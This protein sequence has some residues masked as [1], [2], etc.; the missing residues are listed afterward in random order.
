MHIKFTKY[1]GA[2][3][4]FIILN[5]FKKD[6]S[7]LKKSQIRNLCNRHFGIGAD[8]LILINKSNKADFEMVYHNADGKVGSMCGNGARC[9]VLFCI[10]AGL[11]KNKAMFLAY[12]GLHYAIADIRGNSIKPNIE[13]TMSDVASIKKLLNGF[14]LNTGSPH[15]VKFVDNIDRLDVVAE[16]RKI[17]NHK[18]FKE[19]GINVNFVTAKE[20]KIYI[21]TYER[22]VEDETLACGTGITAAAI[23]AHFAQ[24]IN[25]SKIKVIAK[26]GNLSVAFSMKN[27]SYRNITL[28][29]PASLVFQGAIKI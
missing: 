21:R 20:D 28:K 6:Y 27:Y 16:G 2:G 1:E 3:N 15:F 24:V 22:G 7:K 23:V 11:I 29:G 18:L 13:I 12:D 19:E 8:G 10:H 4:N 17:R 9:A 26:G 14:V 25:Q 5:N